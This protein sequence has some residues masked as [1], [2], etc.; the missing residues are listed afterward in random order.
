MNTRLAVNGD[1][2]SWAVV[3]ACALALVSL[4]VLVGYELRHRDRGGLVIAAT[5]VLAVAGLVLAVVRPVRIAARESAVGA[6]VVVL[7]DK[8]RS[9]ALPN[10]GKTKRLEVQARTL[11]ELQKRSKDARL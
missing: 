8:S 3:L 7:A 1:L 6:K 9:M 10:E 2:P 4:L 5:G 11:E